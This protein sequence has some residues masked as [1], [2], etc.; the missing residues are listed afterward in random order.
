MLQL[1]SHPFEIHASMETVFFLTFLK[2]PYNPNSFPFLSPKSWLF[3]LLY[4]RVRH[5]GSSL[6]ILPRKRLLFQNAP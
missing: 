6:N 3:K 1:K 4:L 2:A 5:E